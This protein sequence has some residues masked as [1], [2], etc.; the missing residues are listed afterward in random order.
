MGLEEEELWLLR[1]EE[2]C[3]VEDRGVPDGPVAARLTHD[4]VLPVG[5]YGALC[6]LVR[7]RLV[8]EGVDDMRWM[9]LRSRCRFFPLYCGSSE[10]VGGCSSSLKRTGV[11][12]PDAISTAGAMSPS[13]V[14]GR[15]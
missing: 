6:D 11:V 5:L 8:S 9:P 13:C 1:D 10:G 2:G 3:G 4:S 12:V 7:R 14:R 15:L